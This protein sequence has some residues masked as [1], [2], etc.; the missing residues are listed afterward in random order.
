MRPT[1][2]PKVPCSEV[3]VLTAPGQFVI[4]KCKLESTQGRKAVISSRVEDMQG[5]VLIEASCVVTSSFLLPGLT[6]S[7]RAIFVE[8]I[9]ANLLKAASSV[10][11]L[12]GTKPEPPVSAPV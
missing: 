3:S 9:Y 12:V 2:L 8:P 5:K 1:S 6:L 4:I 7:I 10:G 11:V